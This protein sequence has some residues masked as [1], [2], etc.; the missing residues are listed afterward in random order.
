MEKVKIIL[1]P[2]V[3]EIISRLEGAGFSAYAVGGC[4]RDAM[5]GKIPFDWDVTTSAKPNQILEV[6]SYAQTIPTGLKHGT[7]TVRLRG[8][9]YE[10]TT[11]RTDGEYR[12]SRH[13][14]NVE[15]VTDIGEDLKRRDF[16]VN[17]M[18]YNPKEGLIDLYGGLSDLKKGI[19]RAVGCPKERF[20]EDALRVLRG[21][22]FVSSTGFDVEEKTLLAMV[23]TARNL[24]AVSVE[25]IF[26]ELDKLLLGKFVKKALTVAPEVIFSVIPELKKCYGFLQHS[27]W[28][29]H[30]VYTHT[31]TAV[32]GVKAESRLRWCMLLHD[33]GKPDKFFI[34]QKGEGH[35]YGHADLSEI[36]AEGILKR[37]KAPT[38]FSKDVLFLIKNHDAPFPSTRNKLKRKMSVIGE[39]A[40]LDLCEVKLADG[41]GQGT[42]LAKAESQKVKE[43]KTVILDIISSGECYKLKDL[44]VSGADAGKI[45]FKGEEIGKVLDETL[46]LVICGNLENDREKLLLFLQNKF[47]KVSQ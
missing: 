41:Y 29:L 28:H 33:I 30:D 43:T 26:V 44:K 4:V 37:L 24:N 1:P 36:I 47:K 39:R 27:K 12:D 46:N 22:R 19:I 8:E 5:L 11:F 17:A 38:R 40:V 20:L 6:F 13:P 35:F 14:E 16:T 23:E 9:N 2:S 21:I 10:V 7:V 25:R 31:A 42:E 3:E 18:A 32:E 34:D 15:F 45:G